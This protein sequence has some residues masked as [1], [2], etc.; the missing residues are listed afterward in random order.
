MLHSEH[1][2][3][4]GRVHVRAC[5]AD[6]HPRRLSPLHVFPASPRLSA[7]AYC[8]ESHGP[9]DFTALARHLREP[10]RGRAWSFVRMLV[11]MGVVQATPRDTTAPSGRTDY[12]WRGDELK[13]LS[14]AIALLDGPGTRV[15]GYALTE[16]DLTRERVI[17]HMEP[18]CVR[19]DP[20]LKALVRMFLSDANPT[21]IVPRREA[22][23][24]L[25]GD[26]LKRAP[27]GEIEHTAGQRYKCQPR[28]CTL[29]G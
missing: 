10:S 17:V 15:G 19:R 27:I 7:L 9:I 12:T 18:M 26:N 25:L 5:I 13:H 6:T 3:Q 23:L 14:E 11:T 2:V 1:L 20:L 22:L 28:I 21:R 8:R 24:W 16:A 4:R 29:R